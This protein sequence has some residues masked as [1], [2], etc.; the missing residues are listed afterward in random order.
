MTEE[1]ACA[2]AAAFLEELGLTHGRFAGAHFMSAERFN[3]LYGYQK[4]DEDFWVVEFRK[5]LDEGVIIESP[6][7]ISVMVFATTGR[8]CKLPSP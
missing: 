1:R 7:T 2:V 4:Y 3:R 5:H 8:T 6:S